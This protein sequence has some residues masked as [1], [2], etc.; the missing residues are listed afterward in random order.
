MQRL[1]CFKH[2]IVGDVNEVVDAFDTVCPQMCF[3]PFRRFLDRDMIDDL[4]QEMRT[5]DR[6]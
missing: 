1:S 3:H 6:F 2:D 5:V 4:G